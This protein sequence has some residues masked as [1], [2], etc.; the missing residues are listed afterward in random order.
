M[1]MN[2]RV[3]TELDSSPSQKEFPTLFGGHM[4]DEPGI[5]QGWFDLMRNL[6]M[7]RKASVRKRIK[8]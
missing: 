4:A 2:R 7:A 8:D 1:A 3:I 5:G 6:C